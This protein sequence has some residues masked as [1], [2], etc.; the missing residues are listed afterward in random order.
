MMAIRE[1]HPT[2]FWNKPVATKCNVALIPKIL[3]VKPLMYPLLAHAVVSY[4][5]MQTMVFLQLNYTCIT[6]LGDTFA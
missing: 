1:L 2:R 3:I 4:S 5:A 6:Y